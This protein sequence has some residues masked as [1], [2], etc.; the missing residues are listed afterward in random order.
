[1]LDGLAVELHHVVVGRDGIETTLDKCPHCRQRLSGNGKKVS[2]F[3][4]SKFV[5]SPPSSLLPLHH[6]S[7]PFHT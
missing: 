6:Q 5:M 2:Y 1:L 7:I 3:R 4:L